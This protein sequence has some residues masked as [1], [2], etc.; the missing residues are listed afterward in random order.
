M[1]IKWI[2]IS[3]ARA[4]YEEGYINLKT[5]SKAK[6]VNIYKALHKAFVPEKQYSVNALDFVFLPTTEISS[7]SV[8]HAMQI[9]KE[10]KALM[11]R[12]RAQETI[13]AK[14][15]RIEWIKKMRADKIEEQ[16]NQLN[17]K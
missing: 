11:K 7:A 4:I 12:R 8:N 13:Q 1:N 17:L 14:R 3:E 9:I 2:N 16:K 15:K 5:I 6:P 10:A